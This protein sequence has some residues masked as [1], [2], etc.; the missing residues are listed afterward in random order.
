MAGPG[1]KFL[2]TF[3]LVLGI[4]PHFAAGICTY[5]FC[6]YAVVRFLSF[7]LCRGGGGGGLEKHIHSPVSISICLHV[8]AVGV[9]LD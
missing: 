1:N 3:I 9:A 6:F 7:F 8:S 4:L 5:F 2:V